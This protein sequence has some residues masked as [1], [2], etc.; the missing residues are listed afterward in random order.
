MIVS[1]RDGRNEEDAITEKPNKTE[2]LIY[3]KKN[4]CHKDRVGQAAMGKMA[5]E[6]EEAS[7]KS[8]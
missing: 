2:K 3:L 1:T 6:K 4:Q 5:L 8:C 7:Y